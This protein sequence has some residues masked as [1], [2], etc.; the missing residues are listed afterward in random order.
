M[1]LSIKRLATPTIPHHTGLN[2]LSLKTRCHGFW[3]HHMSSA[4][5]HGQTSACLLVKCILGVVVV[6]LLKFLLSVE[7]KKH[8]L[9]ESSGFDL[10]I[11]SSGSLQRR[12][13]RMLTQQVYSEGFWFQVMTWSF[14]LISSHNFIAVTQKTSEGITVLVLQ[15]SQSLL[16]D[17]SPSRTAGTVSSYIRLCPSIRREEH[18]TW[19]SV[20]WI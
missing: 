1:Y 14:C 6:C 7:L 11:R 9:E 16:T 2:T 10:L 4:V 20:C 15:Y 12:R 8:E 19:R 17:V 3:T 13:R 18:S 5:K